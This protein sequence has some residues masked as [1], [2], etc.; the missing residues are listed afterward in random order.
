MIYLDHNASTPVDPEVADVVYAALKLNF[1]NPSSSHDI[2]LKAKEAIE[3]AREEVADLIGVAS[4]EIFFTSGGT[5][6]NNIAIRGIAESGKRGHI[7][8]TAIEHPSVTNPC[9]HLR[10]KGFEVSF[11]TACGDGRVD[12][13]DIKKALRKDTVF[14]TVMHANNETGVIQPVEEIGLIAREAGIPFHT[15]AAQ[16]LGKV[17]ASAERLN[18]DMLTV[19][20]HKFYGP[21]GIGAL[22]I[23][24]GLTLKPVIFGAGHEKGLR[25]GT[26]NVPAIAGLGKTCQ[27][28]RLY[29]KERAAHT[30]KLSDLLFASLKYK[31]DGIRLNGHATLRLP[32]TLS[33][34]IPGVDATDL[35]EKIRHRVAATA[36]SACH[37]G[38]KRPSPVLTAMGI[39]EADALSSIRLSTGKDNTEEEIREA[40]SVIVD[41]VKELRRESS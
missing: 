38:L 7:V 10:E 13:G 9:L 1:G 35:L 31:V 5:E 8:S 16:T 15:D 30:K 12:P 24:K 3:K 36:G 4:E 17:P 29:T 32:N 26:E 28:A 6:S 19:V 23:R 34:F 18:V 14:I 21:K 2:G 40:V 20:S 37:S 33:V 41:A 39:P 22:Y 11:V 25:P 27:M